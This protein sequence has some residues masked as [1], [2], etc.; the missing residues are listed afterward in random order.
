MWGACQPS[1]LLHSHVSMWSVKVWP[2]C[3]FDGSTL[4]FGELVCSIISRWLYS[5]LYIRESQRSQYF[6]WHRHRMALIRLHGSGSGRHLGRKVSC[7]YQGSRYRGEESQKRPRNPANHHPHRL[8]Y[9]ILV[10]PHRPEPLMS[11]ESGK[12]STSVYTII[13]IYLFVNRPSQPYIIV[14]ECFIWIT[15]LVII[16]LVALAN[17]GI[18]IKVSLRGHQLLYSVSSK[19]SHSQGILIDL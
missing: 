6:E 7:H 11:S 18:C 19:L 1:A 10:R 9:T 17:V 3:S 12:S 15:T 4:H 5:A 13:T 2:N 16:V 8:I 14:L